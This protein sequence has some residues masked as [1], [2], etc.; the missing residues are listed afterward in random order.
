MGEHLKYYLLT[1]RV[2]AQ[3]TCTVCTVVCCCNTSVLLCLH[4]GIVIGT[5]NDQGLGKGSDQDHNNSKHFICK[6]LS[7]N[8]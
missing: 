1:Y 2:Y 6:D 5:E 4:T 3:Y 8:F 7:L